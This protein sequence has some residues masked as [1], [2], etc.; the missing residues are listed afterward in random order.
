MDGGT[1]VPISK[2]LNHLA[3]KF[4]SEKINQLKFLIRGKSFHYNL[5]L[6]N[7]KNKNKTKKIQQ[8]GNYKLTFSL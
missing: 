2:L 6:K 8:T 4:P 1:R 3:E 7:K 5:T